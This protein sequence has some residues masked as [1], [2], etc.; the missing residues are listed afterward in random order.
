MTFLT[1][2]SAV[3][4]TDTVSDLQIRGIGRSVQGSLSVATTSVP[5]LWTSLRAGR[6]RPPWQ[7]C[8]CLAD[9]VNGDDE[10][11]GATAQA[12]A[13]RSHLFGQMREIHG[14]D[15]RIVGRKLGEA[16]VPVEPGSPL[17]AMTDVQMQSM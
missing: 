2:C 10:D 6:C 17:V 11:S 3:A 15:M 14:E 12:S 13:S 5:I 16:C 9:R 7:Q 1:L 8:A 4:V